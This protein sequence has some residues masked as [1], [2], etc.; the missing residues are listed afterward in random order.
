MNVSPTQS[1]VYAALRAFLQSVVGPGVEVVQGLDNR[2][3]T[4]ATPG[5][6]T[7]GFIAM[8]QILMQRLSTNFDSYTDPYLVSGFTFTG[9]AGAVGNLLTVSAAATGA[10][11]IGDLI[12][13]ANVPYG[14]TVTAFGT[15]T[16]G[17]GTYTLSTLGG[18]AST[19]VTVTDGAKQSEQDTRVDMQIDCYGPNAAD[20]AAMIST[21]FRDDYGVNALAPNCAPLY[22][23]NGMQA[24]L[25]DGEQQYE[26]RIVM[27]A[28]LQYNP[29]T[30]SAQ[31]FASSVDVD[32]INVNEAYPA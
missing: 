28:V 6:A 9:T 32:L 18:F 19:A 2:V 25:I 8:T 5:A 17:V 24:P 30:S 11:N 3:P 21:L 27:Q 16:G 7:P 26:Q 12:G 31:Q 14:T 10:L 20:W 13:G 29:V 4:P 1:N 23:D 22:I 15:G